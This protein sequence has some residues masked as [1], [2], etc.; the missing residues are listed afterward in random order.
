MKNQVSKRICIFC[1]SNAGTKPE[2][3]MAA[4]A[5]G[6]AIGKKNWSLVYGGAS[7]GLMGIVANAALEAGGNVIGVIPNFMMQR[8][9]GHHDLSELHVVSTMHERKAKM[10]E[11]SDAFVAL[12]GGLGTLE[13]LFEVWTWRYLG[14]HQKPLG[15]FDVG[16]YF[17]HLVAFLDGG[18][19]AG[20]VSESARAM[21]F[22]ENEVDALL[23]RLAAPAAEP[24]EAT[25]DISLA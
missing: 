1:G 14:L 2:Y 21:L 5:L 19:N 11:L 6:S 16:G 4:R 3:A 12:P 22:V 24:L 7:V 18:Q 8:E 25:A 17:S 20:F 23:A 9:V 15:L 13:E 10:A